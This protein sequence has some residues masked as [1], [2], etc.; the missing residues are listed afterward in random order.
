MRSSQHPAVKRP[1]HPGEHITRVYLEPRGIT[2]RALA[3]KLGVS[4]SMVCRLL[5]GSC[6]ISPRMAL[7]L[8][9]AIG[10]TPESWLAM[11]GAHDLWVARRLVDLRRVEQ[12]A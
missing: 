3:E 2:G 6:G 8:S 12:L 9:K 11:Q 10:N 4:P 1:P 7:R 5:Q